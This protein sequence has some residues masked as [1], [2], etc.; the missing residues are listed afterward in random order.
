MIKTA[1]ILKRL[2][3]MSIN[4]LI[5]NLAQKPIQCKLLLKSIQAIGC[6]HSDT[7][8]IYFLLSLSKRI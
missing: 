1:T 4:T 2:S 5:Q 8:M 7:Q 6:Y 3:I